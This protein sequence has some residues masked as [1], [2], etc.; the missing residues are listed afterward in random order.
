MP[1]ILI[2]D[3]QT[4]YLTDRAY[5]AEE[6]DL[7]ID[8]AERKVV[9]H[10][11]ENRTRSNYGLGGW[12]VSLDGWAEDDDGN[13]DL[14]EMDEGLLDALRASIAEIVEHWASR[15]DEAEHLTRKSQGAKSVTFSDDTDLPSSV[16]APCRPFDERTVLF[17]L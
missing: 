14:E 4:T 7:L 5:Q 1:D 8:R 16:Y 2:P 6:L 17:S 12:Q 15:P 13:P 10:Y 3:S 11:R 9:N